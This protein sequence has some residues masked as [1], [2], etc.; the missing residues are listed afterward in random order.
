MTTIKRK[1]IMC[2]S[3]NNLH[4]RKVCI[5]VNFYQNLVINEGARECS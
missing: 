3:K 5:H 4:I 1:K 2:N